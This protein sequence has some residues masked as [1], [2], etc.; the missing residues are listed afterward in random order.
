MAV[1]TLDD[2]MDNLKTRG[3]AA[4]VKRLEEYRAKYRASD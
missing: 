1:I 4:D 2:I 3:D